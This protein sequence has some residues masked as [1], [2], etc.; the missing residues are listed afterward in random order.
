MKRRKNKMTFLIVL[1]PIVG[2]VAVIAMMAALA[3]KEGENF[4]KRIRAIY[5]Y[6]VAFST[7]IMTII[8]IIGAVVKLTDIIIP[9]R[10]NYEN[11]TEDTLE[12]VNYNNRIR[13]IKQGIEYLGVVVVSLPVFIYHSKK[14]RELK[15]D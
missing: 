4:E 15:E 9:E 12:D 6:I 5:Y 11:Y 8:G 13:N 1:A 7:L 3:R 14:A 2:I 10:Y